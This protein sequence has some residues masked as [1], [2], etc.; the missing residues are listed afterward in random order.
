[1]S[2]SQSRRFA[3]LIAS[4][5]AVASTGIARADDYE[6]NAGNGNWNDPS[7]WSPNGNPTVNDYVRLS[8]AG[9]GAINIANGQAS[10]IEINGDGYQ[11]YGSDLTTGPI[12]VN[13]P[14]FLLGVGVLYGRE[15]QPGRTA[16]EITGG[17]STDAVI[18]SSINP[19]PGY[20][21]SDASLQGN[22]EGNIILTGRVQA[23]WS[24]TL[25]GNG[26]IIA[27]EA[28]DVSM[29]R[30]TLDNDGGPILPDRL[31]D[32]RT[33]NLRASQFTMT[34]TG[35]NPPLIENAGLIDIGAG[36]STID[37]GADSTLRLVQAGA[38]SLKR[39]LTARGVLDIWGSGTLIAGPDGIVNFDGGAQK[40]VPWIAYN[41]EL[42]VFDYG[43]DQIPGTLDDLGAQAVPQTQWQISN[44]SSHAI[45]D[46]NWSLAAGFNETVRSMTFTNSSTFT[47]GGGAA[48]LVDGGAIMSRGTVTLEGTGGSIIFTGGREGVVHVDN[49]LVVNAR[50]Q[51]NNGITKAGPGTLRLNNGNFI[52]G[53]VVINDGGL[54]LG[55]ANAIAS[56][57]TIRLNEA[58]LTLDFPSNTFA[59]PVTTDTGFKTAYSGGSFLRSI[60]VRDNSTYDFIGLWQGSGPYF[61][62]GT[63][64]LVRF[65]N[66]QTPT[67][68]SDLSLW[69]RAGL[70]LEMNSTLYNPA[71]LSLGGI[72]M[73][74]GKL[75]GT[76]SV[77]NIQMSGGEFT[78][79]QNGG[80][81]IG[82][83][84]TAN[85]G[86]FGGKITFQVLGTARGTQYD[87]IDTSNFYSGTDMLLSIPATSF[88]GNIGTSL[89]I[90]R[91]TNGFL[92]TGDLNIDN[93]LLV[94]P[95]RQWVWYM[96][97]TALTLAVAG[98]SGDANL[99]GRVNF[100]DLLILAANYNTS[101][102]NGWIKG[103]F[104]RDRQVNFDD[105][106]VLAA[107]YNTGSAGGLEGD[108][109]LAL[110]SVP[111][112]MSAVVVM[113]ASG[114]ALSRRRVGRA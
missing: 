9:V 71:T 82:V 108:W 75:A 52:S 96:G 24:M 95:G 30:L 89:E 65:N 51:S 55:M 114:L 58:D 15:Y 6:W 56:P 42:A 47:L 46:E 87:A 7:R 12:Y 102:A 112:P 48:I 66:N 49:S 78:P 4:T 32:S 40:F 73:F 85:L 34:G 54:I 19:T 11:L 8:A 37:I 70:T 94:A 83:F 5:V 79:G 36:R 57:N 105:L 44:A 43:D 103:D 16:I 98:P 26:R 31:P 28:I 20:A 72:I 64:S 35:S 111:E 23:A 106:L 107:N 59:N 104:N 10:A 13:Q 74:E 86:G 93:D 91:Y 2:K 60:R 81:G 77:W 76:G 113:A 45:I 14:N 21:F 80:S 61:V 110:A 38:G 67:T 88:V 41:G 100:D 69:P 50:L 3:L 101:P 22:Y 39:E 29:A 63:N 1:M 62:Q 27:A 25:R 84:R 33:L 68:P 97:T 90:I 99:D 17:N 92:F 18:T 53:P 109:A